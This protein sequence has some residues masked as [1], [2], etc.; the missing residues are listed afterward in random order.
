M[1]KMH[2]F[3]FA[4]EILYL[5]FSPLQQRSR[6]QD[7][8]SA[9]WFLHLD[10]TGIF[11]FSKQGD[12][13]EARKDISIPCKEACRR[14]LH[15]PPQTAGRPPDNFP[16]GAHPK[17]LPASLLPRIKSY[18]ENASTK[19]ALRPRPGPV[20]RPRS[21]C[22]FYFAPFPRPPF[23]VPA[24]LLECAPHAPQQA[25]PSHLVLS[26]FCFF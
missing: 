22:V 13:Q 14:I 4:S 10:Q 9:A 8:S 17:F 23:P 7:L 2:P 26:G 6:S 5:A 1:S 16:F 24:L 19:E 15:P 18:T 25:F 21:K 12:A 3:H 11:P 20:R